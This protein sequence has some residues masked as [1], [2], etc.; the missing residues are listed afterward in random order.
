MELQPHQQRVV[1]EKAELDE[2]LEKLKAFVTGEKFAS[3]PEAEQA[4]LV[5]QHNIMNAYSLVLE[6]RIA[7][8]G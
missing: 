7:A 3:V 8:F 1:T 6:M 2:K 4:R 5:L